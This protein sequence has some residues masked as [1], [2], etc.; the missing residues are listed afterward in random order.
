M[1]TN[2]SEMA[3]FTA[4]LLLLLL[5]TCT[6]SASSVPPIA[7]YHL[8]ILSELFFLPNNTGDAK[9]AFGYCKSV[10]AVLASQQDLYTNAAS[11]G[12]Q[13]CRRG[14]ITDQPDGL[15]VSSAGCDASRHQAGAFCVG[16]V[17]PNTAARKCQQI[18]PLNPS[19]QDSVSEQPG[20]VKCD[21]SLTVAARRGGRRVFFEHIWKAGG[22]NLNA[23]AIQNGEVFYHHETEQVLDWE[24][25][26]HRNV[27]FIDHP[28]P[29]QAAFPMGSPDWIFVLLLRDPMTQ[30]ISLFLYHWA[31]HLAA[32]GQLSPK[33][34]VQWISVP[35][36]GLTGLGKNF[37]DN[38]H[39]RWIC[40]A[41]CAGTEL[42]E[43]DFEYAVQQLFR[44]DIVMVL[45]AFDSTDR[46]LMGQAGWNTLQS[47]PAAG[48][49]CA[50]TNNVHKQPQFFQVLMRNAEVRQALNRIQRWDLKLYQIAIKVSEAQRF[51]FADPACIAG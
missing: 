36:Q 27:T 7:R 22:T 14:Y 34:F 40:G 38:Q 21:L 13:L 6:S 46:C 8:T 42:T 32:R 2:V 9:K 44:F 11:K 47:R 25:V 29:M 41:R 18:E 1:G 33:T 20:A 43:R 15:P 51:A 10:G 30:P 19:S 17:P 28:G 3:V 4:L 45:E 48:K 16:A 26:S 35:I 24:F 23:M 49:V 37:I 50:G 39:T 12:S 5:E 31:K